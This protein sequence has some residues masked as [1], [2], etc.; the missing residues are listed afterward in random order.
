MTQN[1]KFTKD[2]RHHNIIYA[3]K[4]A[5]T[6]HH[7]IITKYDQSFADVELGLEKVK[8]EEF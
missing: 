5:H 2:N 1:T 7:I 3:Y 4:Y 6:R 8:L